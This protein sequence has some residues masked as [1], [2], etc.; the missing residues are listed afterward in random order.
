MP[1]K[2]TD[3]TD[4]TKWVNVPATTTFSKRNKLATT[5]VLLDLNPEWINIHYSLLD[6]RSLPIN[7]VVAEA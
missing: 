4:I 6:S 5:T 2:A 7:S 1:E 3:M